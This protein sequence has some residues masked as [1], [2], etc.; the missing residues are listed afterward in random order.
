MEKTVLHDWHQAHHGRMVDFAGWSM[1]VQYSSIVDEHNAVRQ[2]VG[3]FD[4]SHM[5]RIEFQG[6]DAVRFLD[7]L[8]TNEVASLK[9][10]QV[11]YSLVC[12]EDGGIL[13]DVLVYRVEQSMT[14]E[15]THLLV[16]NASNREKIL[17]WIETQRRGFDVS[18]VDRTAEWAM[19]ALQGPIACDLFA[20]YGTPDPSPFKYYT[21]WKGQTPHGPAIVSRT[22]YTGEDGLELIVPSGIAQAVWSD[23]ISRGQSAGIAPCGLGC[24]DTLRLEAAMPLYGHELSEEIDPLTAGLSFAVKLSK[25]FVG[26]KRLAEI[27]AS[28]RDR[29]R[30][31]LMLDGRRI[32]R[33]GTPVKAGS[34]T[35]GEVTSGT[36]SPTLQKTIAMAYLSPAA[37]APGTRIEVDL[38]GK[39]EPGQVASLPFYRRTKSTS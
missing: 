24:R 21:C 3:L 19:I 32:A 6:A 27:A 23:L 39:L 30:A 37:S 18:V 7:H 29:V 5:G 11:R 9:P 15:P 33:E 36:F 22:G 4:I 13:D 20:A 35:V 2:R 10:G 12:R 17:G 1:P 28:P 25:S 38:R 26:Q 31:G 34:E 14:G 8:L 16:V